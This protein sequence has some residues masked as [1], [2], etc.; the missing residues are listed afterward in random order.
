MFDIGTG[1]DGI[2][3]G[4]FSYLDDKG[5][6]RS[7]QY[8][9]GPKIGYRVVQDVTGPQTHLLPRPAV[10]EFGILY[11]RNQPNGV[12]NVNN[13]NNDAGF[14]NNR[15]DGGSNIPN[16]NRGDDDNSIDGNDAFDEEGFD[17]VGCKFI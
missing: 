3:R 14:N 7:T 17:D 4:S 1:P 2:T 13:V 6:Q 11:P 15:N 5:T 16:D 12:D 9:A 8:I 10:V